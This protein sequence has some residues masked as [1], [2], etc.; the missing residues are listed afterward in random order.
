MK[1][2]VRKGVFETNS[3]SC[4]SVTMC[5]KSEYDKWKAG[6][7]YFYGS[8][9]YGGSLISKKEVETQ[10]LLGKEYDEEELLTYDDW[11]NYDEM[12]TFYET[13]K[14]PGGEEVVAFGAY[15]YDG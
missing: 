11:Q 14:T 9:N 13:Y 4:H 7:Y 10:K 1:E 12:E 5:T 6:D 3:S 15:G 8:F 2:T